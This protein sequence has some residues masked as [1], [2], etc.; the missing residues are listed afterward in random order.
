MIARSFLELNE[1]LASAVKGLVVQGRNRTASR[2][3]SL[4]AHRDAIQNSLY[5]SLEP[6]VVE[7]R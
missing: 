1:L 2:A 4:G 5:E 3:H 7:R 6:P